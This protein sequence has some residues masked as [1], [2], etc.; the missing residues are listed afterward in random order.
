MQVLFLKN[1][2]FSTL[3]AILTVFH[4]QNLPPTAPYK[5]AG[6]D[7]F[8]IPQYPLPVL[9]GQT[10]WISLPGFYVYEKAPHPEWMF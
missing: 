5:G 4:L 1:F 10:L 3:Y 6:A 2:I 7:P 9:P 8:I